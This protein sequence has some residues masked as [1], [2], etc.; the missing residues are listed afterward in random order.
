MYSFYVNQNTF[1][2]STK[3]LLDGYRYMNG[4]CMAHDGKSL[5]FAESWAC[6]VHRYWLEGPKAGTVECV[7]KDMPGY[8]S[9]HNP[10]GR[11]YG[12]AHVIDKRDAF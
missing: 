4:V 11:S 3:T 5:F 8:L 10:L 2:L 6:R 12:L 7:I 9:S 1:W